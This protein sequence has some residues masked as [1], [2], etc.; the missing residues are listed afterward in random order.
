[1]KTEPDVQTD[2]EPKQ[3]FVSWPRT[4]AGLWAL[5]LGL[6]TLILPLLNA[7]VNA[8]MTVL[9]GGTPVAVGG[10][11]TLMVLCGV[12]GGITGLVA[13]IRSHE[14]SM[15]VWGVMLIG[16]IAVVLAGRDLLMPH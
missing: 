5:G 8:F 11:G 2:P 1:M 7:M 14:H 12:A 9:S 15:V 13:L 10:F 3:R 16:L 6:A 4:R